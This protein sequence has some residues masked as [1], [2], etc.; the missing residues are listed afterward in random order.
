MPRKTYMLNASDVAEELSCSK[1]KA[2]KIIRE[3]NEEL[4]S[5]GYITIAG[6]LPK[7]Y[8]ETKMYGYNA[9]G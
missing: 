8:W 4:K 1:Q 3:C 5:K 7:A 6:K 2:Y 9:V